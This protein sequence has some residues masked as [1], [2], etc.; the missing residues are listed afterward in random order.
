MDLF[1]R[2]DHR[3][4]YEFV[5][6]DGSLINTPQGRSV[7]PGHAI[8]SMWFMIQIYERARVKARIRQAIEVIR[9]H[10]EFGWDE[11]FGGLY[12]A[13]DAQ[14][15]TPWWRFA[16][17]KLWWPHTEALVALL[18]AYEHSREPWCLE[19]LERV[20]NY[21]FAHFPDLEHGEWTQKLDRQG[22]KLTETVALPVKDPFHLPRALIYCC[23]VLGRL[24]Q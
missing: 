7:V 2:P 15:G 13:R 14:G 18:M 20:H 4:L 11:E 3:L 16:D 19:W 17:A 12:H 6:L 9:W 5:G 24:A 1:V 8:E 23:D 22:R 21:A 10:L